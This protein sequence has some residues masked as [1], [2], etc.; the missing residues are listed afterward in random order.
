M[1]IQVVS[2]VLPVNLVWCRMEEANYTQVVTYHV[3]KSNRYYTAY[4]E[5]ATVL[6]DR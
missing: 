4:S 5:G 6:L 3:D 2:H 1:Q